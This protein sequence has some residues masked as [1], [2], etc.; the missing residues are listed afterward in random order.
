MGNKRSR[1]RGRSRQRARSM[2]GGNGGAA[3]VMSNF[4]GM[5][6]QQTGSNGSIARIGMGGGGSRKRGLSVSRGRK[7]SRGRTASRGRSKSGGLLGF[8]PIISQALVPF[9]LFGAQ[10]WFR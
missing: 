9:T 1:Q 8:G 5:G 4:G 6:Q 7:A 3:Y 2:K 10:K